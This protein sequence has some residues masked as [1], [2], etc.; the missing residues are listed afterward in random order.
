VAL[1]AAAFTAIYGP[2]I[3]YQ[4]V[5]LRDWLPPILEP[6]ILLMVLRAKERDQAGAW[7]S[8]GLV[9][10]IAT[11][12]KETALA[13]IAL[14]SF[15]LMLQFRRSW[16]NA[17]RAFAL[18]GAGFLLCLAPVVIRNVVVGAPPFAISVQGPGSVIAG[19]S[20][21]SSPVGFYVA[22]SMKVLRERAEGKLLPTIRETLQTHRGDSWGL[23][24]HQL[25]KLRALAG[26]FEVPNNV[27]YDYG[28][29]ISP[30][31]AWTIG[32]GIVF[33]LGTAGLLFLYRGEQRSRLLFWY[34]AAAL[35]AQLVTFISS[36]FRIALV[37]VLILA[38]A[39]AIVRI[40]DHLRARQPIQATG[41]AAL[42]LMIALSQQLWAPIVKPEEVIARMEY[43]SAAQIYASEEQFDRAMNEITQFRRKAE[44]A[45]AISSGTS[46]NA[47]A[48][49][50]AVGLEGDYHLK[51]ASHLIEHKKTDEA[52][53][54]IGLAEDAYANQPQGGLVLYN[55]GLVYL[56]VRDR[57]K[58]KMLFARY[59]ELEPGGERADNVRRLL[60]LLAEE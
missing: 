54:H 41:A 50:E 21:G 9:M 38:A 59:L 10:G 25:L 40:I 30:I 28:R 27:S 4:G 35:T 29:D 11:L 33:P 34:L 56:K 52:R 12:T 53:M 46:F 58:A 5:L 8:A 19:L 55:L 36:R 14:T 17:V 1:I 44:R 49:D 7:L 57:E 2:F 6:L 45:L 42:V 13:L 32:Y 16:G 47:R 23:V 18:L 15:W 26:S 51:W 48:A 24:R 3:F 22:P 20:A 31:L 43:L 60:S 39:V 37:P